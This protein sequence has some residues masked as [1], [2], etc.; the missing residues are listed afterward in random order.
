MNQLTVFNKEVF[1]ASN[2]H[3]LSKKFDTARPFR[4]VIID[5][6]LNEKIANEIEI[7][8]P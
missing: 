1:N 8:F 4:F 3:L 6:F 5:N 7:S 2:V